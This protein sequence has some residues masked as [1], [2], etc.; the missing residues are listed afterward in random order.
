MSHQ[1]HQAPV[2]SARPRRTTVFGH[3]LLDDYYWLRERENPEVIAHLKAEN[4]YTEAVLEHTASLQ[5][6]LFTELVGYVKDADQSAPAPRG[7][8][9]Y[10][11]R[12]EAGKQYKIHCRTYGDDGPEEILLDENLLARD[13]EYFR[14]GALKISPDQRLLAYTSDTNGSERFNLF[15]KD[16]EAGRI[17]DGPIPDVT[18]DLQWADD[19]TLIYAVC[20]EAW[21]TYKLLRHIIGSAPEHD[22]LVYHEADESFWLHLSKTRSGAFLVLHSKSNT[23]S[24]LL[25]LPT[26]DPR[27][28][29]RLIF[30]RR[31]AIEMYLDHSGD[32]F[33]LNTNESATNFKVVRV[34]VAQ[35]SAPPE[36]IIAHNPAIHVAWIELFDNHMV[37]AEREGGLEH[38]QIVDLA[39]R[40]LCN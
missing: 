22:A 39:T 37:V 29:F 40:G 28:E 5:H 35:P 25:V 11:E 13:L 8:Y 10:Y 34:P 30:P 23:T 24:E 1:N 12:T 32:Y 27:G 36:E 2:A 6:E 14:L 15:V 21:R 7:P 9:R 4:A 17:I 31:S 3:E 20:D 33:Y 38:L 26:D 18:Y 19:K 16:L